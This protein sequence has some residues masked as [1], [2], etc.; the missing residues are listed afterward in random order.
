MQEFRYAGAPATQ[1]RILVIDDEPSVA[2]LIRDVLQRR[3][4]DVLTH[5]GGEEALELAARGD[6][7]LVVSDFAIP[8]LNGLEFAR[9]YR[10]VRP[11]VQVL[12]VSAFLD[13]ETE[14][15]LAAQPNV[16]GLIRKPFDIFELLRE[17]E[18]V[19][20]DREGEAEQ[21]GL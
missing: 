4:F 17:V 12:I 20:G 13:G 10:T 5:E 2:M 9:R 15:A 3:G 8:G 21:V 18:R 6:I 16:V 14:D 19:F 11:D 7:D 1:R